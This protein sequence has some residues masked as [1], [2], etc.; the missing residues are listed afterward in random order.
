MNTIPLPTTRKAQ[1][2][3]RN[4]IAAAKACQNKESSFTEVLCTFFSESQA[5]PFSQSL[6]QEMA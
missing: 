4:L 5:D 3:R 2:A 6:F 1:S